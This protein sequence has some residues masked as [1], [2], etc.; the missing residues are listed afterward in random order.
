[1]EVKS[2]LLDVFLIEFT[3]MKMPAIWSKEGC[4]V[5]RKEVLLVMFLVVVL[6][7][8]RKGAPGAWCLV[9]DR[10]SWRGSLVSGEGRCLI[11]RER[12]LFL[13]RR[14]DQEERYLG[15]NFSKCGGDEV[16]GW[17]DAWRSLFCS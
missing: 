15:G 12:S 10:R 14:E 16:T 13:K 3:S 1:M 8:G 11:R 9:K 4:L 6:F 5:R 2:K 17:Y 7:F